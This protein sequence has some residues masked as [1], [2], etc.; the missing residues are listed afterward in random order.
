MN[1]PID[2]AVDKRSQPVLNEVNQLKLALFGINLS[3]GPTM[4]DVEGRIAATWPENLALAQHADRIGLD[5]VVPVARWRGWGG[6]SNL[7]ERSFETFT[8]AS[9]LLA[10]TR[11]IQVFATFHVPLAHPIL[12]AKMATT[13]DH[14]SG[15]RFGI[16]IVAGWYEAELAMFGLVQKDHEARYEVADEWAEAVKRLW[17]ESG[18]I[19][20][21]GKHFDIA[22]GV[23]DPKPLQKPYPV[24]MNAGTSAAGRAFAAKHSDMMFVGL[25]GLDT[26]A[27]Q[28]NEIKQQALDEH[29][30]DVRVFARGHVICRDTEREA[31]DYY[32][33]VHLEAA[34]FAAAANVMGITKQ[35]SK[36]ADWSADE[37]KNLEAVTRGWGIPM[38]GSP[39]QVAAHMI[40]ASE[41]GVDGLALSFVD[42]HDGL[43]RLEHQVLPLLAQAGVR[44]PVPSA[45]GPAET[46]AA[47]R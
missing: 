16:N 21:R 4:S 25:R 17:T 34:D 7:G 8:W 33:Y 19:N 5:A 9:G 26:A 47:A 46:P 24:I 13:A 45:G 30:R 23:L 43:E 15:G 41:A 38:V 10:S 14:I 20:Y 32:N 6:E 2:P 39:E 40:A 28:V 36:R 29:G 11:N 42:Y 3:G 22:R 1:Q 18:E 37:R 44:A 12:A 35:H 31:R 27:E